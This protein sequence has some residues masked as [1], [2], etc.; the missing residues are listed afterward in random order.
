VSKAKAAQACIDRFAGKPYEPGKKR[1]CGRLV[2]HHLHH[3]GISVPFLKGHNWTSEAGAFRAL[4]KMGFD[5]L[6]QAVDAAGFAR[7]APAR[8]MV[9]DIVALPA[10]NPAWDCVLTVA[11]GNG[12]VLGF[13]DGRCQVVTPKEYVTAWRV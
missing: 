4:R 1:D 3:L 9:G 6:S 12:R 8:A 5:Q 2:C 10:T 11:V 13:Y 7:I